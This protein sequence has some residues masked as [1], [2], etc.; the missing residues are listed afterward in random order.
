MHTTI[1]LSPHLDD[2]VFSCGAIIWDQVRRHNQVEIWTLFAADAPQT[3][4][5]PFAQEIHSRWQTG[6]Q[7]PAE[8]RAEDT[9]ACERLGAIPRYLPYP[10]CIYRSIPGT[11]DPL[12]Q[13]N[14]DLFQPLPAVEQPLVAEIVQHLRGLVPEESSL[15][16]PLAV[17]NHIDHQITRQVGEVL[18]RS[19]FYYADFPYSGN[20]PEG[21]HEL[22]PQ[23][24]STYH[25][26]VNNQSLAA[27]QYAIEAYGTQLSTFWPSL[28]KMYQAVDTYANSPLGNC[29]WQSDKSEASM[30]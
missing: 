16:I 5:T 1:Y 22:V 19:R 17:G 12:I 26:P 13:K 8:R 6:S 30:K 21:I 29:L 10:D 24:S 23:N 25:F 4:L 20:Q 27:W 15:I 11:N 28:S 9:L 7:A 14:E 2:A 18:T 3:P